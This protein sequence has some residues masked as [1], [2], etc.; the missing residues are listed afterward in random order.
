VLVV[1]GNV[2]KGKLVFCIIVFFINIITIINCIVF[3][4]VSS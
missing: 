4:V 2:K 1:V 3:F